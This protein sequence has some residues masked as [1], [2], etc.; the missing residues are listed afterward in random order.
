MP[1]P[2]GPTINPEAHRLR[3]LENDEPVKK[4]ELTRESIQALIATRITK[5]LT[6]DQVDQL[7]GFPKHTIRDIEAGRLAPSGK[8]MSIIQKH[9]GAVLRVAH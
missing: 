1:K 8:Q 9:T 4:R 3:A 7:C 6:Q 5:K 2:V